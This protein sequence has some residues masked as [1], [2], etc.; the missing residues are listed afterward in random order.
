MS[1]S[2]VP[3]QTQ[4]SARSRS[5]S[6]LSLKGSILRGEWRRRID[7]LHDRRILLII[8][9]GI[10][11][12]KSLDLIRRLRER[13]A[14]VRAIMTAAA[15]AFRDA[16]VGRLAQRGQG[17]HRSVV[18]DRRERD[19]AYPPV[20]R[21]R[22][23]RGGAG[24]RRPDR[25]HGRGAGRRSG[26]DGVAC[27]GQEGADRADDEFD[28]VGAPGDPGQSGHSRGARGGA[29]RAGLRRACLRRGRLGADGR[30]A[31]DCRRDRGDAGRGRAACRPAGIGDERADARADRPGALHLEPLLGQA[32]P[33]DRG[34]AERAGR[35]DGAGF[36]ADAG[37]GAGRGPGR[38]GRDRRGNAGRLR[39]RVARPMSR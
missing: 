31:G 19:G 2:D 20:A 5:S 32:G 21:G 1:D 15:T 14:A 29:H 39:S 9:G 23:N 16:L 37:A 11:A 27:L 22:P 3:D 18:A 8:S 13:G 38:A 12:Y 25:A 34:G 7:L 30:A 10:A 17:L 36:G 33:R 35:R 6:P 28:D 24:E 4:G 26:D